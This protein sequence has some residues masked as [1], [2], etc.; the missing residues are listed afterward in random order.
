MGGVVTVYNTRCDK[1]G[2]NRI[3]PTLYCCKNRTSSSSLITMA[4]MFVNCVFS[5][6]KL[7]IC[8]R[9]KVLFDK[10]NT[11]CVAIWEVITTLEISPKWWCDRSVPFWNKIETYFWLKTAIVSCA[12]MIPWM[13]EWSGKVIS[14]CQEIWNDGG[15]LAMGDW[16]ELPAFPYRLFQEQFTIFGKKI[17]IHSKQV[18]LW[19]TE[20]S[21]QK[22]KKRTRCMKLLV[23][24]FSSTWENHCAQS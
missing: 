10:T 4:V 11:N 7:W 3:T 6:S 23:G 16:L 19:Q 24:F 15:P 12:Q 8:H 18:F 14:V 9:Y 1:F 13:L 2:C 20:I 5:T 21:K 22:K 17:Y